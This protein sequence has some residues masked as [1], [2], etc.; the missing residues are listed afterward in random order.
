MLVYFYFKYL[1]GFN[2]FVSNYNSFDFLDSKF[3]PSFY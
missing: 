3:D 2:F 1:H